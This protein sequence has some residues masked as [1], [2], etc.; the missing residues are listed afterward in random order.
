MNKKVVA[1]LLCVLISGCG[2]TTQMNYSAEEESSFTETTFDVEEKALESYENFKDALCDLALAMKQAGATDK[3]EMTALVYSI[4]SV[5]KYT[6]FNEATN[7]KAFDDFS[8]AIAYFYVNYDEGLVG[9]EIGE[10]GFAAIKSLTFSDG[11]YSKHIENIKNLI[12]MPAEGTGSDDNMESLESSSN[13]KI[14]SGQY[15]I[16]DDIEAGEYVLF[17]TGENP[18]YFSL[19]TDSNG[20][21]IIAN[22]NFKNCSIIT[23]KDGEY[24]ELTRCYALPIEKV[25]NLAFDGD[26]LF[27]IGTFLPAGEYKLYSE[28]NG[29]YCIYSDG[30]HQNIVANNNFEGQTYVTVSEGQYLLLTRC[31]II[32]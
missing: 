3:S 5:E 8:E 32:D 29:Y 14:S 16:G 17:S 26:A 27:K 15:K 6:S 25:D 2:Q 1:L 18:G 28:K 20:S 9:H 19:T 4:D 31:K 13:D 7:D 12:N 10:E 22:D 21:D 24:L 11:E 23:V 30:R